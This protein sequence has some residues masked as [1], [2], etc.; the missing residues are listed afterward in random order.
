MKHSPLKRRRQQI[1]RYFLQRLYPKTYPDEQ[2][3]RV[4]ARINQCTSTRQLFKLQHTEAYI[5]DERLDIAF[6]QKFQEL[7]PGSKLRPYRRRQLFQ[8]LFSCERELYITLI[9]S[10]AHDLVQKE[11]VSL[12]LYQCICACSTRQQ[13]ADVVHDSFFSIAPLVDFIEI[14]YQV[15]S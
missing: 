9:K 7:N 1:V 11:P 15:L 4:I 5:R 6:H 10:L 2:V 13:L 14:R 8:P 3:N 12:E